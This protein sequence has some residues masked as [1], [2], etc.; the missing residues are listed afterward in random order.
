MPD[1]MDIYIDH[2]NSYLD[3][4]AANLR[5]ARN[6]LLAAIAYRSTRGSP[7][8][9]AQFATERIREKKLRSLVKDLERLADLGSRL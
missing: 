8:E 2:F 1:D 9:I 7:A 4:G 5:E 6:A 3:S